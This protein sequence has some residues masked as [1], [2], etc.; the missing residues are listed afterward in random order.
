MD[1]AQIKAKYGERLS[2]HGTISVQTTLPCGT[3]DDVRREVIRRIETVGYNGGLMVSPEN[4]VPY[5]TPLQNVLALYDTV[6]AYDYRQ[7]AAQ[8]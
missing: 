7:L 4:S 5:N 2:F 1:P 8:R 6:Q 3:V